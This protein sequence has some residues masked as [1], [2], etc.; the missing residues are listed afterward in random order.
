[1]NYAIITKFSSTPIVHVDFIFQFFKRYDVHN[2][3]L[4]LIGR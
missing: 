4:G 1:M 2:D 3:Y